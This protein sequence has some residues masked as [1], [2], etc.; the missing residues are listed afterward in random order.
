LDD[1]GTHFEARQRRKDGKFT[2]VEF[3]NN[4]VAEGENKLILCI[5][6][7]DGTE[8]VIRKQAESTVDEGGRV[9]RVTE[10]VQVITERKR[11][12]RLNAEKSRRTESQADVNSRVIQHE[13]LLSGDVEALAREIT[14]LASQATGCERVNVWLFNEDETELRC[15]DLYEATPGCHSSGMI[16]KEKDFADEVAELKCS[17]YVNADDPLTDPRTKGYVEPYL[18][19]LGI[20]SM[21]DTVIQAAGQHLGL[22][23]FEHV[24]KSHHWTRDEIGFAGQLADKIGISIIS[25]KRRKAERAA[26]TLERLASIGGWELDVAANQVVWSKET[27]RLLGRD[28]ETFPASV[29]NFVLALHPEDRPRVERAIVAT[30]EQNARWEIEF[31]VVRPDKSERIIHSQ[32]ETVL[33]KCGKVIRAIGTFHDITKRKD[34]ELA[35]QRR[36]ALLHAIAFSARKIVT[37]SSLDEA[38]P[39]ILDLVAKT[40]S[41][42]R[43]LVLHSPTSVKMAP[44]LRYVWQDPEVKFRLDQAFFD[45]P[46]LITP[47]IAEWQTPLFE[48]RIVAAKLSESSGDLK[49]ML[50]RLGTKSILLLP[51]MING[52]YWGQISLESSAFERT[53]ENFEIEVMQLFGDLVINAIRR[54]R[55]VEEIANANRIVQNTP[56]ILLR[57]RGTPDLPVIYISQ[58]IRL[59][60]HEPAVMIASPHLYKNLVHPEDFAS[61]E[62][63]LAK[64]FDRDTDH[65]VSEFRLL[66]GQGNYRWVEGRYTPIRD[67]DGRLIEVEGLLFDITDRKVSEEK[68]SLLAHT[69]SLTGLANRA[70]FFERLRQV[71]AAS[72]RGAPPF[73][74]LSLDVDRFKEINDTMGH[75]IGDQLLITVAERLKAEVR[76]SDLVARL[77]GDEFAVL[78]TNLGGTSDAG[79]LAVKILKALPIPVTLGG[80]ELRITA[81]IGISTYVS[82]IAAPEELLS[83]ADKALYRAKEDGRD[84]YRFHTEELDAQVREQVAITEDLGMAIGRNE[85]EL[86]YQPR[87]ELGTGK[88]VGMEA[89][90]RWHHLTRGLLMPSAFIAIAEKCGAMTS[91]GE[92]VLDRACQQ[93]SVWR[94]AKIAPPTLAVNIS[95]AQLKAGTEFVQMVTA[96]LEKW[97]LVPEDL[98]LD[99]TESMLARAAMTQND[100]LSRLQKLGI[101]I[102][103]DDFGTGFSTLDYL[104]TYRVNRIQIPQ[105]LIDAAREDPG[106]ASMVRAIVGIASELNIEVIAK[107]VESEEQWMHLVAKGP[108]SKVQGCYFGDP[109]PFAEAEVLLRL[110]RIGG[111]ADSRAI[112]SPDLALK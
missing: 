69:D 102:S 15:I 37:T 47:D 27:Y 99:V 98:E 43:I 25:R 48:G 51:I 55:Y 95:Y 62:T 91:I 59:L 21:L 12:E 63:A 54:E 39:A 24:G 70:T 112:K 84:Q 61:V 105:A 42:E 56:T 3:P 92:W 41:I 94:R 32:C 14:E 44:T 60:G 35:L 20:T 104:R 31:R 18:K 49:A 81:S 93:M 111:S 67:K 10:A 66:T 72:R 50:E 45:D 109:V 87:V 1:S 7:P 29:A 30:L 77:G 36:D 57:L 46:G 53:W 106:S 64:A 78:Q 6:R 33:D 85:F 71:F 38:M 4:R 58:N 22:L 68:I 97:Q 26:H 17:G 28:P 103:I 23:C 110:G 100:I 79:T 34:R 65:V 9:I 19:P 86:Y 11:A 80:N 8:R 83:Q 89:L 88:I 5:V 13:G 52:K 74:L 101:K 75:P 2:D 73:A 16:L 40:L 90:I 107:G 76:E 82:E 96:T 108:V